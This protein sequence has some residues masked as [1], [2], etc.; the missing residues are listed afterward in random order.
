MLYDPKWEVKTDPFTFESLIAWLE[1]QPAQKEYCFMDNG[2]CLFF[3]YL[4]EMGVD[5][6]GVGGAS[7]RREADDRDG[8]RHPLPTGWPSLASLEPHTFGAALERARAAL[9]SHNGDSP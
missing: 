1:R 8:G 5:V 3:Q 7:F 9:A 6:V 4:E 2:G